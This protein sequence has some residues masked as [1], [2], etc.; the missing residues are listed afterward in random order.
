MDNKELGAL[1]NLLDDPDE[2]IYGQVKDK[3]MSLGEGAIPFLEEAW[4]SNSFGLLFQSRIEEIIHSIQFDHV[5]LA[6]HD[7]AKNGAKDL[8]EGALLIARYQ[9]P[10]LDVEKVTMAIDQF[11]QDVW[12]ELNNN[13]TALE[14]VRIINHI[15]FEVHRFSGNT[16]NYHAPQNSYINNVLDSK[17]GN[18]LSLSVLYSVIA[19]RL[20]LPI[21]GVNLPRHFILAYVDRVSLASGMNLEEAN[22]LF[23]VNPFSRGGVFSKKEID[24]FLKQLKLQ[25]SSMYYQPCTNLQIVERMFSNLVY[26]YDKLG[27]PDKVNDIKKLAKA[28]K[29]S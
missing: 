3:I 23:Y 10:D 13:L 8:L 20:D 19:Q 28:L 5:Y 16:V 18:P 24:F 14:Q 27:Y 17:K 9:Y 29:I 22:V 4:E 26:S 1:I 11:T 15:L 21:Y 6:L 12:I 25:P 7:W 2:D